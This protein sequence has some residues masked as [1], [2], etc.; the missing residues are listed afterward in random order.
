MYIILFK[1]FNFKFNI[2]LIDYS[3]LFKKEKEKIQWMNLLKNFKSWLKTLKM[4]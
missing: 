4:K 2:N 3:L 1:K